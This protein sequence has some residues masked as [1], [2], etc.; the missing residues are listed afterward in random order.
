M[1]YCDAEY[2]NEDETAGDDGWM[3]IAPSWGGWWSAGDLALLPCEIHWGLL[4]QD[5][6][7]YKLK[8]GPSYKLKTGPSFFL[9]FF[10]QFY[11]VF[12]LFL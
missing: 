8:T 9:L 10:P 5:L 3:V 1:E 12:W 7:F 11:S 6:G 2:P 4:V